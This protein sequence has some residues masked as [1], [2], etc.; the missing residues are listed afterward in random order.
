MQSN[1]YRRGDGLLA[2]YT[3]PDGWLKSEGEGE[4]SEWAN[5]I[6]RTTVIKE[7]K[8][9]AG[10]EPGTSRVLWANEEKEESDGL[11]AVGLDS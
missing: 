1:R 6:A 4:G 8:D 3:D 10:Q 11:R 9:Q 7:S 5:S 2:R